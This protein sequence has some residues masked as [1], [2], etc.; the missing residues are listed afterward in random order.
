MQGNVEECGAVRRP[1]AG[2]WTGAGL[3]D[4]GGGLSG[5]GREC[6]RLGRIFQGSRKL[7]VVEEMWGHL[8]ELGGQ[9]GPA[10]TVQLPSW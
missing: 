4:V 1:T 8:L 3:G 5:L 2:V 7:W 9:L 10:P 6:W